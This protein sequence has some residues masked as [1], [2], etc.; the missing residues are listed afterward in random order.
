ML[1]T[2]LGQLEVEYLSNETAKT[3]LEKMP[4]TEESQNE[5]NRLTSNMEVISAV[6]AEIVSQIDGTD[7]DSPSFS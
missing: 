6:H 7:T 4:T 3:V 2:R 1:E 5:I